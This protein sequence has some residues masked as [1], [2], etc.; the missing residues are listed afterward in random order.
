MPKNQDVAIIFYDSL[1]CCQARLGAI[2]IVH[3]IWRD[4]LCSP[5]NNK[6]GQPSHKKRNAHVLLE[7]YCFP[8]NAIH[9]DNNNSCLSIQFMLIKW[10]NLIV[11]V[12]SH[13]DIFGVDQAEFFCLFLE[14]GGG[15]R[16]LPY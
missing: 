3:A 11:A 16:F 10:V 6:T 13:L 5:Q 15:T 12:L 7:L 1:Q 4:H 9:D 8:S 2:H 14:E